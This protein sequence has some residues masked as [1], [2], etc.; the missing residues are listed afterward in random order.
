MAGPSS[1]GWS[2]FVAKTNSGTPLDP[3]GRPWKMP[4][5]LKASILQIQAEIDEELSDITDGWR[6]LDDLTREVQ[7]KEDWIKRAEKEMK[8]AKKYVENMDLKLYIEQSKT[9][10]LQKKKNMTR[11]I[12]G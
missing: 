3:N 7:C 5:D 11:G 9:E 12:D 4:P 6:R 2:K 10:K 8:N 1:Q